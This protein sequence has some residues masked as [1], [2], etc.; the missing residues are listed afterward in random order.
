MRYALLDKVWIGEL[1]KSNL[2]ILKFLDILREKPLGVYFE[3]VRMAGKSL[4]ITLTKPL[5]EAGIKLGD[6]V[7]IEVNDGKIILTKAE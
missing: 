7:R 2:Y 5:E 4:V 1:S 3:K 6:N